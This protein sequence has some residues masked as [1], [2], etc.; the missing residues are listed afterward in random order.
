[1]TYFD[2]LFYSIANNQFTD[3]GTIESSIC[4]IFML[5]AGH[6]IA[7]FCLQND[8]VARF[9]SRKTELPPGLPRGTWFWVLGSHSLTH[10]LVVF[11]VTRSMWLGIMETVAHWVIDFGKCE[12][13]CGF[14]LDQALHVLC[15]FAWAYIVIRYGMWDGLDLVEYD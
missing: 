12:G 9:K 14:H 6:A 1:M 10:G 2:F 4:L 15:K 11:L 5:L 7:D 8:F 13:W 3:M